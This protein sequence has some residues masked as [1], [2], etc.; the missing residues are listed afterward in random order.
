MDDGSES[1]AA[2]GERSIPVGALQHAQLAG[3][4]NWIRSELAGAD[5][6]P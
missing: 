6:G 2:S 3:R 1:F 4:E 5:A